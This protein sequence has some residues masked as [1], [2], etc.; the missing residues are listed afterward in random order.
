MILASFYNDNAFADAYGFLPMQAWGDLKNEDWRFAAG[1][2]FDVFNPNVPTNLP[3]SILYS[4]KLY[5]NNNFACF[6]FR[7]RHIDKVDIVLA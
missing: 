3:F 1:L 6:G 2:Q 7:L 5:L 4:R